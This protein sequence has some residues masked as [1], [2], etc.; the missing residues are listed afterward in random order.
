MPSGLFTITGMSVLTPP[1]Y[2]LQ[3]GVFLELHDFGDR[4][5]LHLA[6]LGGIDL[7]ARLALARFEQV[8]RPQEAADVVGAKRGLGAGNHG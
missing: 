3:A 1:T 2:R 8:F 5:V 6:Q 4:L 7:A